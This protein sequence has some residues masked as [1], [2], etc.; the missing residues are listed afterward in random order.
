VIR[1]APR[2][3]EFA[4]I[5]ILHSAAPPPPN[6]VRPSPGAGTSDGATRWEPPKI[7]E[8]A[9]LL[10]PGTGALRHRPRPAVPITPARL[11]GRPRPAAV[12]RDATRECKE[13]SQDRFTPGPPRWP[14][15]RL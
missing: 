3:D 8:R 12:H 2:D 4:G 6:G 5:H 15:T 9:T 10:R 14:P 1:R 7:L 13:P 11:A